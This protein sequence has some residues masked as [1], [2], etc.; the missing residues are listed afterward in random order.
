MRY[1]RPKPVLE[2][3]K[4]EAAPWQVLVLGSVMLV[5]FFVFSVWDTDSP[6]T[7][8]AQ[9]AD[10]IAVIAMQ[11]VQRPTETATIAAEPFGYYD[12]EWNLWEYLG[13]LLVSFLA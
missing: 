2:Q 9:P 1:G 12:G 8:D 3:N 4:T 6:K 5:C 10:A 13:D 11:D 7:S